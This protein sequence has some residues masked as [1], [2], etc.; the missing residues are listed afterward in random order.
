MRP[1]TTGWRWP[2]R[3]HPPTGCSPPPPLRRYNAGRRPTVEM[4][5]A[6]AAAVQH[7]GTVGDSTVVPDDDGLPPQRYTAGWPGVPMPCRSCW[8]PHGSRP[9]GQGSRLRS[10]R[11][12]QAHRTVGGG[13]NHCR[14]LMG[15]IAQGGTHGK[16]GAGRRGGRSPHE[17]SQPYYG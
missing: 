2:R 10:R 7:G 9:R 3:A 16:T 13:V 8:G 11:S 12:I 14:P 15:A 17:P 1:M 6:A 4:L 5:A